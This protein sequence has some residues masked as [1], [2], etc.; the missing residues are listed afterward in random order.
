MALRRRLPTE[1]EWRR[2]CAGFATRCAW[3]VFTL[4]AR[5][6]GGETQDVE[7]AL[8]VASKYIEGRSN[9][10]YE[11]SVS[12]AALAEATESAANAADVAAVRA[13][14]AITLDAAEK[15]EV[16]AGAAAAAAAAQAV[17]TYSSSHTAT[18]ASDTYS[19]GYAATNSVSDRDARDIYA[20]AAA[21]DLSDFE[22]SV[23]LSGRRYFIRP[24][25]PFPGNVIPDWSSGD[26]FKEDGVWHRYDGFLIGDV[27][28][29]DCEAVIRRWLSARSSIAATPSAELRTAK[30]RAAPETHRG[31]LGPPPNQ[32]VVPTLRVRKGGERAV[33]ENHG[34]TDQPTGDDKLGFFPLAKGVAEFLA[35]EKTEAPFT[36]SVEGEWGTGK[37]SFLLQV[38]EA[39]G[40]DAATVWFNPWRHD[41]GES[42]WAAFAVTLTESLRPKGW[43]AGRV[44]DFRYRRKTGEFGGW[45]KVAVLVG[46]AVL[47]MYF[48]RQLTP[49][50]LKFAFN[51]T[52][53]DGAGVKSVAEFLKWT[54]TT[55]FHLGILFLLFRTAWNKL[56]L[57]ALQELRAITKEGDYAAKVSAIERFQ[58]NFANLVRAYA[59]KE[60]KIFVFVDDLDRCAAPRAGE[61]LESLALVM[62]GATGEDGQPR[63]PLVFVRALDRE[64][65][66]A[67]VAAKHA[68]V[69]PYL[70]AG[71]STKLSRTDGGIRFGYEYLEKF[72][73][74]PFRLPRVQGEGLEKY[75]NALAPR[76]TV[77]DQPGSIVAQKESSAEKEGSAAKPDDNP[78]P[79]APMG[80]PLDQTAAI[81]TPKETAT[82]K[83]APEAKPSGTDGSPALKPSVEMP[84]PTET[85]DEKAKSAQKSA[86]EVAEEASVLEKEVDGSG[87]LQNA[88]RVAAP[89]LGNNPRRLKHY[90]NLL[91]LQLHIGHQ[92]GL[93]SDGP[94]TPTQL[95]K[96]VMIEIARP[97]LYRA[98]FED[99]D[100]RRRFMN[101][102]AVGLIMDGAGEAPPLGFA[103]DDDAWLRQHWPT[104]HGTKL[105]SNQNEASELNLKSL[106]WLLHLNEPC[107][108]GP[109]AGAA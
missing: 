78:A 70:Q 35:A 80:T 73:H 67:G 31:E 20:A 52:V 42:M 96:L 15:A 86:D 26:V 24:L 7:Q 102:V 100:K 98:L 22:D 5:A 89:C 11:S 68:T 74:V 97:T 92:L 88:L 6:N 32:A 1:K 84:K 101:W 28:W 12:D 33:L 25:W 29:D 66:A 85:T 14:N 21:A 44:A 34:A 19:V 23:E 77:L 90:Q 40:R 41:A 53:E 60:K 30:T 91:R 13:R 59:P 8:L 76:S 99:A 63:L 3:R 69:L 109:T 93:K 106:E 55:G 49:A 62:S 61:L 54:V 4:Y 87:L 103:T 18:T 94:V 46:A 50:A 57:D 43:L 105:S 75:F 51:L 27:D 17:A 37:S 79:K 65:V 64:K 58:R 82:N 39:L 38:K 83:D 2:A 71:R 72:I 104:I 95:A 47:W 45:V 108:I 56:G 107:P 16:G 9:D 48:G 81:T 10:K 36:L